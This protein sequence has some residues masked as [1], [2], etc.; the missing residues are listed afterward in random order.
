M[1]TTTTVTIPARPACEVPRIV[2]T[3]DTCGQKASGRTCT[4]CGGDLCRGCIKWDDR[5]RSSD[6]PL[7]FCV[8]CWEIGVLYRERMVAAESE[9]ADECERLEK[10]WKEAAVA[11]RTSLAP[12]GTGGQAE[13]E[14]K[15]EV[16]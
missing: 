5:N 9:A 13:G 6:Y 4:K 14:G 3:C 2:C 1:R 11:A 7:A 8:R 15:G 10:E 12:P 16:R